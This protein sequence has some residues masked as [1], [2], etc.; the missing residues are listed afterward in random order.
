MIASRQ[1]LLRECLAELVFSFAIWAQ[2]HQ[3]HQPSTEG[4]FGDL[5]DS[6]QAELAKDAE[7]LADMC[8][9]P[10]RSL[11]FEVPLRILSKSP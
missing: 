1:K 3:S 7:E 11:V 2:M 4:V 9:T 6:L 5:L 8:P 10:R